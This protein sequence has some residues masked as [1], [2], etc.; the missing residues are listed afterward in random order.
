MPVTAAKRRRATRLS[1]AVAIERPFPR[2]LRFS[3]AF[4]STLYCRET[5]TRGDCTNTRLAG[6]SPARPNAAAIAAAIFRP[7]MPD[8]SMGLA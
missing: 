8:G 3:A 5:S 4:A 1:S 7:P 2:A 6:T